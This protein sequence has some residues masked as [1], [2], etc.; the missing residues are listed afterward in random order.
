LKND[1]NISNRNIF[2]DNVL[3][4]GLTQVLTNF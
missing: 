4:S 1:S 2:Y 3:K